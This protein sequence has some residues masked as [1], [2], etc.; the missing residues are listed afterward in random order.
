MLQLHTRRVYKDRNV[1]S[2]ASYINE[3]VQ[4]KGVEF[5][6]DLDQEQKRIAA[7]LYFRDVI[8]LHDQHDAILESDYGLNYPKFFIDLMLGQ[9]DI[10]KF[11]N[12]IETNLVSYFEDRIENEIRATVGRY[13]FDLRWNS[14]DEDKE[15]RHA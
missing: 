2:F 13:R 11:F 14:F 15:A 1:E 3:L 9:L 7:G 6:S 4:R 12:T 8:W 5:F 10:T